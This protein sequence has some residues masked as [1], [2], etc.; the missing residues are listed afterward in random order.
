MQEKIPADTL[1]QRLNEKILGKLDITKTLILGV[2]LKGLPIAL[3]IASANRILEN[4]VPVVAHR[5][6]QFQHGVHSYLPSSEWKSYLQEQLSRCENMIIIDDVVNSG[7]TKQKLESVAVSLAKERRISLS[8]AAL[9]LNRRNLASPSLVHSSDLFALQVDAEEVECDWGT[10]I[11]P[12]WDLPVE[13]ARKR[14]GEYF[15]KHWVSE[16]RFVTITY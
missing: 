5:P 7:F 13:E 14:C 1:V 4:F 16:E 9:V 11:V 3:S 2:V 8:F 6:L 12:L 15:Q 10:I